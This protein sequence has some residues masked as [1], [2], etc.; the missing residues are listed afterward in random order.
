[1]FCSNC[2]VTLSANSKFCPSCGN[3][4][5]NPEVSSPES[6]GRVNANQNLSGGKIL[7]GLAVGIVGIGLAA[8]LTSGGTAAVFA[9]DS[10]VEVQYCEHRLSN[11]E[12][13]DVMDNVANCTFTNTAE[14][15]VNTSQFRTWSYSNAG[16]KLGE[17]MIGVDSVEP[18]RSVKVKLMLDEQ[19]DKA[20]MCSM[21]PESSLGRAVVG[22]H[23]KRLTIN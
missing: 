16:V 7:G 15:P 19:A 4:V 20:Y 10:D 17:Y 6:E 14:V 1:M 21:D 12:W 11:C 8:W 22:P 5:Q 18:G 9:Q 3:P 13:D 2:G 23:L